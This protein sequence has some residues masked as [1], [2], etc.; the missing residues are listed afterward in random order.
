MISFLLNL[1]LIIILQV[2]SYSKADIT[3]FY[4]ANYRTRGAIYNVI[5]NDPLRNTKA[6]YVP[7]IIYSCELMENSIACK[8]DGKNRT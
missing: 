2:S 7:A 3:D 5:V 1:N 4:Q 8:D 6:A